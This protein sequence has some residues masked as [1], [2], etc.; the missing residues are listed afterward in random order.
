MAAAKGLVKEEVGRP[1]AGAT[2]RSKE[3]T[4][5]TEWSW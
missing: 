5:M 2:A 1:M 4:Q 3:D